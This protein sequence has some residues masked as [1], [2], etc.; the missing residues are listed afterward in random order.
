M[1]GGGLA[2]RGAVLLGDGH[3]AVTD[4][5]RD[6]CAAGGNHARLQGLVDLVAQLVGGGG[7]ARTGDEWQQGDRRQRGCGTLIFRGR[8][9]RW[10]GGEG[11][12][13]RQHT[14]RFV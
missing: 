5:D 4:Q 2:A 1:R 9:D 13:T 11:Q 8:F 12:R 6:T 3:W 10:G 14:A 7:A